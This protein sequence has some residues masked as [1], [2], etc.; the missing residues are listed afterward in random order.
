MDSHF[1]K[2]HFHFR[3]VPK[4]FPKVLVHFREVSKQLP[5]VKAE[6]YFIS[7]K[8]FLNSSYSIYLFTR[9]KK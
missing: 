3:E 5:E 8:N 1:P 4:H 2:V 7:K 6:K 9:A